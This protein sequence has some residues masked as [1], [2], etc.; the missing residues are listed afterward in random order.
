MKE[1]GGSIHRVPF[2]SIENSIES[3]Y[4]LILTIVA[5]GCVFCFH[6]MDIRVSFKELN[7]VFS[8]Y[9]GHGILQ[10]FISFFRE[11]PF[12][13]FASRLDSFFAVEQLD[14][15]RIAFEISCYISYDF[16][17]IDDHSVQFEILGNSIFQRSFILGS[18]PHDRVF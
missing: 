7:D 5:G 17:I 6:G 4:P 13:T 8:D 11:K 16:R 3:A 1:P 2:I 14:Y 10:F 12:F 18:L 9:S 15:W